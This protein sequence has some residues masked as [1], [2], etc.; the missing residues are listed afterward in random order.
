MATSTAAYLKQRT[1]DVNFRTET[2]TDHKCADEN[3]NNI[4]II[5]VAKLL[6]G[7]RFA[8]SASGSPNQDNHAD[9]DMGIQAADQLLQTLC[10]LGC[11]DDW[12]QDQLIMYMAL[13]DGVSRILTGSLTMHTQTAIWIAELMSGAKFRVTKLPDGFMPE[14]YHPINNEHGRIPNR[15]FIECRGIGYFRKKKSKV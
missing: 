4:G 7:N 11:V 8:A 3:N 1:R 5:C 12:L 13:A 6:S 10:D 15:H 14:D 9:T 2:I